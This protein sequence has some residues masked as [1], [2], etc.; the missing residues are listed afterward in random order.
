MRSVAVASGLIVLK[1]CHILPMVESDFPGGFLMAVD[2]HRWV[3][4]RTTVSPNSA[5]Q[6]RC[7]MA[8]SNVAL[9]GVGGQ[10]DLKS[11]ATNS[12]EKVFETGWLSSHGVQFRLMLNSGEFGKTGELR[13]C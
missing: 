3:H 9:V 11:I 7:S 2:V 5:V 1:S 8:T 12:G 13:C 6:Y 4:G 10:G